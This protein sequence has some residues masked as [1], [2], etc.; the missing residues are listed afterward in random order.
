MQQSHLIYLLFFASGISG[1]MYEVVWLRMLTRVTG[2]TVYATATVVAAFMAGLA[3]GSFLFG[4]IVDKRQDP[5]RMYASLEFLIAG[6]ALLVPYALSASIPL[7]GYVHDLSQG[8]LTVTIAARAVVCFV[9]LLVPTTLMGG[10]LPILT[11]YLVRKDS[12]FGRHLSLLYG[13]NTLGAVNGVVWSGFLSIGLVGEMK[14]MYIGAVINLFVATGAYFLFRREGRQ[15]GV[16]ATAAVSSGRESAISP[17]PDR[18][19][20]AV[21]LAFAVSGFTALAYEV[22]WTRQLILF[23]ETSIYAFSGMLALFLTG[24][25]LGS[26]TMNRFLEK[27]TS[28]LAVF[29]IL[30][31]VVG[32]LSVVNLYLFVPLDSAWAESVFGWSVPV[33]ASF[34]L[35]FPLTFAFG[36]I[37]PVAGYCYARSAQS[38]GAATGRLYGFNTVGSILGSLLAGFLF[39]PVMGSTRAVILMAGMNTLLGII[40][41]AMEPARIRI[42][43]ATL[44]PVC[45]VFAALTWGAIGNDPFLATV[46]HRIFRAA[47]ANP[48]EPPVHPNAEVHFNGETLE[49]TVTAFATSGR[50]RLWIN[51]IGM[52]SLCTE[53]KLMAHLPLLFARDPKELLVVCFGMGTT[54]RSATLH[55]GLNVAAV[56]LVKETFDLFKYYHPDAD[57]VLQKNVR[58]IANDGRNHLLFNPKKY[59]VITV[60]P[61]PPTYSAGTV[62][63][64]SREFFQLCRDRLT[65]DGVMCLWFPGGWGD[66][67][68]LA[69]LRTFSEVFPECSVW[70]G[71]HRWGFYFIGTLKPV[72]WQEF[73]ERV[74]EKFKDPAFVQDLAE[75][76]RS[77]ATPEQLY[78]LLLWDKAAV[79]RLRPK[80]ALITDDYPFTEFFL[81]R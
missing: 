11:S 6:A 2:V 25:A 57:E 32:L 59:D 77:C 75:Y 27:L 40:L 9:L 30:E 78:R 29:G 38:A 69:I 28:P 53:T 7:F 67:D 16:P 50:K 5:L 80:G 66:E 13:I 52:T 48:A 81:V 51:G 71:P 55:P 24:I 14:T 72:S 33:V 22:I 34:I 23:L 37:F 45:L 8:N 4:R 41:V 46:E 76:D 10:T 26:V 35:V 31:L 62:N 3:L 20:A 44:V 65:P 49:G 64:Y 68:V 58:L 73:R 60:D 70:S 36:L 42:R 17:Y 79:D 74:N 39:V 21:L 47:Q 19:R 61:A 43:A 63:L 15:P 12:R 56:E 54:V 1:L 18:V